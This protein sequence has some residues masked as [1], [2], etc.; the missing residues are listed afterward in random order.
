MSELRREGVFAMR[1][2]T[3]SGFGVCPRRT[4][5]DVVREGDYTVGYSEASADLGRVFHD[6]AAEIMRTLWR[7]GESEIPTQEAIEILFERYAASGISLPPDEREALRVC[8]LNL[9]A[10]PWNVK[11]ALVMG[12]DLDED[13]SARL[14]VHV[15]CQDGVVREFNG[16]PDLIVADPPDGVVIIDY[17]TGKGRPKAPRDAALRDAEVV[18]GKKYLSERGHAQLDGYGFLAM[19]NYPRAQR[20]ILREYHLRSG[21]VREAVLGRDELEHVSREIGVQLQQ[22]DRGLAEGERSSVWKPRPGPQ[23][24]RQCPVARS[25]PVPAEQRGAGAIESWE[26]A[27]A[28]GS[29]YLAVDGLRDQLRDALAGW[30]DETGE[31]IPVASGVEL[32]R[33]TEGEHKSRTFGL[34]PTLIPEPAEDFAATFERAAEEAR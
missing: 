4:Y 19:A 29:R 26:D 18:E 7:T 20:A 6:V 13:E 22:L 32:R 3:V 12:T 9:V 24:K 30:H 33:A 10:R 25:C 8:V 17:K 28:Q 2:S 27:L 5:Y 21:K 16:R 1:Q 14:R 31:P 15:T 34:W 11:G 23:C